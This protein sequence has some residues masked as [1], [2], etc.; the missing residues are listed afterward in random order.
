MRA[1]YLLRTALGQDPATLEFTVSPL[2]NETAECYGRHN[3][4]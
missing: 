1:H 2:R 4:E 3:R